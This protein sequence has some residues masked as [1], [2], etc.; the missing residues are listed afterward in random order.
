[1]VHYRIQALREAEGRGG[2][3]DITTRTSPYGYYATC[4]CGVITTRYTD[5]AREAFA[6]AQEH[7]EL[8][9]CV[10]NDSHGYCYG[11]QCDL[12]MGL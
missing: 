1:M 5:T 2:A 3:H 10:V 8:Q 4:S 11:Q 6:D 7:E 12:C 9:L